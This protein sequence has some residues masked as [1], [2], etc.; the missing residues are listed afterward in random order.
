ITSPRV[1][2]AP[3]LR[4]RATPRFFDRINRAPVTARSRRK[5]EQPSVEPSSTTRISLRSGNVARRFSSVER[6]LNP[7]FRATTTTLI[8]GDNKQSAAFQVQPNVDEV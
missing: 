7:S 1:L 5:S 2:R 6:R 4:A 3:V 8:I